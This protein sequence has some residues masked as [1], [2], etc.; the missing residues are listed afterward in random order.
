MDRFNA[1]SKA[2]ARYWWILAIVSL[3]YLAL[4][5]RLRLSPEELHEITLPFLGM[6][7][8]ALVVWAAGPTTISLLLLG[9]FGVFKARV[10]ALRALSATLDEADLEAVEHAL[11]FVDFVAYEPEQA[12]APRRAVKQLVYPLSLT[13][14]F[15]E[16]AVLLW[17]LW[18]A[19]AEVQ[20]WPVFIV[21]G[22][23]TC[24]AAG[25]AIANHWLIYVKLE[26]AILTDSG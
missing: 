25:I 14:F 19:R 20:Y 8:D 21:V 2:R 13:L 5:S 11:T 23:T 24:V 26:R 22:V 6:P 18:Q 4:T 9:I 17:Q 12:W 15:S 16:A 3:F 10:R 1:C 7:L